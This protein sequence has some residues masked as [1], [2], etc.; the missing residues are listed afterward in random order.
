MDVSVG[1]GVLVEDSVGVEVKVGV[2]VVVRFIVGVRVGVGVKVGVTVGVK[3]TSIPTLCHPIF[4][5]VY[6]FF[7]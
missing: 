6:S 3:E 7:T 2:G 4:L 5:E 1:V